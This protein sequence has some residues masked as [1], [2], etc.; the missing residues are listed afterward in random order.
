MDNVRTQL[1]EQFL[2]YGWREQL[3]GGK[4]VGNWLTVGSSGMVHVHCW[5]DGVAFADMMMVME[6]K[7]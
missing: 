6:I 7:M 1:L 2:E 3:V 4:S 5:I